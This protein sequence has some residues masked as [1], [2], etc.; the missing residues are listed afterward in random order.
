MGERSATAAEAREWLTFVIVGAGATGLELAGAL[1]EIANE[2]L[3]DDFR[4]YHIPR[5]P[6]INSDGRRRPRVSRLP[7]RP[8]RKGEKLVTRLGVPGNEGLHGHLHRQHRR[9]LQTRR[10][11]PKSSPRKLSSGRAVS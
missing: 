2:T 1:A 4:A 6:H 11:Q 10:L 7:T 3:K 5:T 9:H 8:F